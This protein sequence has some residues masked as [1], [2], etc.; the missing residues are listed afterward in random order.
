MIQRITFE[1]VKIGGRKSGKCVCGKRVSRAKTF[2][3]TINPYNQKDGRP[4]TYREIMVELVD[5]RE[6]WCAI[7]VHCAIPD[8]WEWTK[9]Q[10]EEYDKTGKI[11]VAASCGSIIEY[12]RGEK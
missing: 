11:K 5:E 9:A 4:K 12:C 10:R 3:Q 7:P 6:K 1:T 2:E 8:Y